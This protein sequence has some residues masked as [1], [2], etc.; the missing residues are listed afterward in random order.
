MLKNDDTIVVVIDIQG[1]LATLMYERAKLY[2]SLYVII[3]G[4]KILGLPFIWMEQIPDKIGKTVDEVA[5]LLKDETPIKKHTFSCCK[6]SEFLSRLKKLNRKKILIVGIETHICVYQ[7]SIDLLNMGYDVEVVT[8]AVSSRTKENKEVGIEKIKSAG[9]KITSS[10]MA[11]FELL[12]DAKNDK[13]R[14]IVPF[15]K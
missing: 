12:E 2:S 4:C 3:R 13:F 6:N 10:E 15:L 7:T 14:K 1:K 5:T 9:G 8:D 11:L